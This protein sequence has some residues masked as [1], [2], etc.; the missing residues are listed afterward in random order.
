MHL[1]GFLD[2]TYNGFILKTE[3]H[4]RLLNKTQKQT[5]FLTKEVI[6]HG[7]TEAFRPFP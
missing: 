1:L 5:S 7:G 3:V 2:I 4:V 6:L